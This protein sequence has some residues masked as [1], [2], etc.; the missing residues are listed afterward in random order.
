MSRLINNEYS[1]THHYLRIDISRGHRGDGLYITMDHKIQLYV[2]DI[3]DQN[4]ALDSILL[5][6]K[7]KT[8]LARMGGSHLIQYLTIK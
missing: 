6:L 3:T 4:F 7:S 1:T 8:C 5:L 2:P